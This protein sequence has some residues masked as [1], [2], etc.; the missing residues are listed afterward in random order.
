MN[1]NL[2]LK[3]GDKVYDSFLFPNLEGTV[4]SIE[5]YLIIIEFDGE[6]YFFPYKSDGDEKNNHFP[7]TLS[8]V[9]YKI[10]G[11]EKIFK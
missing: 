9:P 10:S 3:E 11:F 5:T 1:Q 4:K 7:K 8:M 2:I 6:E